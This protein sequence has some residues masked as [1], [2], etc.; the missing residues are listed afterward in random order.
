MKSQWVFKLINLT[1][2]V[3]AAAYIVLHVEFDEGNYFYY[4]F[5]AKAYYSIF[6]K[7]IFPFG[8]WGCFALFY[9][10][11]YLLS[12]RTVADRGQ[13]RPGKAGPLCLPHTDQ[14]RT[15]ED[16]ESPRVWAAPH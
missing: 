11:Y 14:T 1:L 8:F 5:K 4:F 16:T 15:P 13:Q 12:K 9:L 6:N 7:I 2:F 3:F 10:F